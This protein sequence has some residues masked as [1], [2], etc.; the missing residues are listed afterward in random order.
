MSETPIQD[1][2]AVDWP[3]RTPRLAI[4]PATA[5]DTEAFY[6]FRSLPEVSRWVTR[7]AGTLEEFRALATEP[8]RLAKTLAIEHD[9][10][11]VGDL[12]IAVQDAWGQAEVEQDA[13]GVQAELGWTL[14][15]SYAGR[16]LATEAVRAVLGICFGPL[17]LRRVVAECFAANTA[18]WRLMERVGMRREAHHVADSLHRSGEWLDGLT[19]AL[20]AEEWH[21]ASRNARA[22]PGDVKH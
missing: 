1:L 13:V 9:G 18:S 4:R 15:P 17:G 6:A 5:D 10:R 19:Y 16:G 11:V 8:G 3:V 2:S 22:A 20:L 12:M 14:H 7:E 21:R